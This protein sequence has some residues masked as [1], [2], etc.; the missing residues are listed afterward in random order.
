MVSPLPQNT[1]RASIPDPNLRPTAALKAIAAAHDV[2]T[3]WRNVNTV[4]N[5]NMTL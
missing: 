5:V 2:D 1:L 4:W 3:A